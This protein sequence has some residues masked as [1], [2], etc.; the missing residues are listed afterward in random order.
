MINQKSLTLQNNYFYRFTFLVK[1]IHQCSVKCKVQGACE[2]DG[3]GGGVEEGE[4]G[5]EGGGVFE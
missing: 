4:A 3:G 1:N 2:V 5:L